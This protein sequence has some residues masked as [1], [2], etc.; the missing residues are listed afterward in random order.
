VSIEK[1]ITYWSSIPRWLVRQQ[2]RNVTGRTNGPSRHISHIMLLKSKFNMQ[3]SGSYYWLR[4]DWPSLVT[5]TPGKTMQIDLVYDLVN[6]CRLICIDL[7]DP[8]FYLDDKYSM[9]RRRSLFNCFANSKISR[10]PIRGFLLRPFSSSIP[11]MTSK[12][13]G[14]VPVTTAIPDGNSTYKPRFID[15]SHNLKL[16]RCSSRYFRLTMPSVS[17]LDIFIRKT[18][19]DKIAGRPF[20]PI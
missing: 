10:L 18:F 1:I 4:V 15:V 7:S 9:I 3:W 20:S 14:S 13:T 16:R 17:F 11:R 5:Q 19:S 2:Q 12:V 6:A 8:S